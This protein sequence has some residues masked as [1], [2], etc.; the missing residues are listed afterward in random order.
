MSPSLLSQAESFCETKATGQF[1]GPPTSKS[2]K[3]KS[4]LNYG[5]PGAL[6]KAIPG[7]QWFQRFDGHDY[8]VL[9]TKLLWYKRHGV[10]QFAGPAVEDVVKTWLGV[11][12]VCKRRQCGALKM[13]LGRAF[14]VALFASFSSQRV[15]QN[16][17]DVVL[18]Y[19][20]WR[21]Q[22]WEHS[23]FLCSLDSC[24]CVWACVAFIVSVWLV[25]RVPRKCARECR[26]NE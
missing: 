23:A 3:C 5:K 13:I 22:C 2:N 1:S 9:C 6:R 14:G 8:F 18:F 20:V 10:L 15:L 7:V 16:A 25:A 21:V 24:V 19:L 11:V 26:V 12:A 4:G 17:W